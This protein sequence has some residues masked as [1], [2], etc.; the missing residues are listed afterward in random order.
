M[1]RTFKKLLA[2]TLSLAMACSSMALAA[3][4]T[5][6]GGTEGGGEMEGFVSAEADVFSVE[7]P[8]DADFDF[9][10]DP[11]GLIVATDAGAYGGL[12]GDDFTGDAGLYFPNY[13]SD[14]ISG[15][16]NFSDVMTITNKG[17]VAITVSLSAE[18]T[19][20]GEMGV[21]EDASD[22]VE[23]NPEEEVEGVPAI[24]LGV[25]TGTVGES[26]A[27]TSADDIVAVATEGEDKYTGEVYD[28]EEVA[29]LVHS[30]EPEY[31]WDEENGYYTE[32]PEADEI[33]YSSLHFRLTGALNTEADWSALTTVAPTLKLVWEINPPEDYT[34]EVT[35]PAVASLTFADSAT[36]NQTTSITFTDEAT[37]ITS[38]KYVYSNGTNGTLT[39]GKHY[40]VSG[41]TLTLLASHVT[42]V[43]NNGGCTYT[44]TFNDGTVVTFTA[45]VTTD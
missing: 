15:Y 31:K 18:L 34:P 32:Y 22:F 40:S 24:Y 4:N 28:A 3:G 39:S 36:G 19:G 37:S 44:A 43:V 26:G 11:Q 5:I 33:T 17:N 25:D 38:L 13:T 1:K 23:A 6:S 16:S 7:L 10:M 14:E 42:Y 9:T 35:G 8:T 29:A 45:T 2:L 27:F 41:S 21:V 20:Y 30:E 12:T